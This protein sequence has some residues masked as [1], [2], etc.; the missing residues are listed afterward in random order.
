MTPDPLLDEF[1]GTVRL[2]PLP[3]LVLFPDVAQPLH[4]FERRYQQMLA[5]ALA[6]DRLIAMA[7]LRPGWE[8]NYHKNPP[9]HST[10]CIGRIH[11]EEPLPEGRYNLLLHGLA[12]ARIR[13]ETL[14]GRLYRT[15]RVELIED[16]PVPD[17]AAASLLRQD[18][19]RSVTPFFAAHPPAL[20]QVRQLLAGPMALGSLCDIVSFALPLDLESKQ[21]LLAEASVEARVRLL[22]RRLEA[23]EPP[24]S[25]R[26]FPP[27]FSDN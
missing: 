21:A 2:F 16:I 18:L 6:G 19:G 5:D 8:Q 14:A 13:E 17:P 10:V 7:L 22:L 15:A 26:R 1:D 20:E 12:R 4:I 11:N 23:L 27:G 25:S 3:N 9:I 24:P